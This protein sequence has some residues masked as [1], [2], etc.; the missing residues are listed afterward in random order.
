MSES[1]RGKRAGPDDGAPVDGGRSTRSNDRRTPL[2]KAV[3][4]IEW[5]AD[6]VQ[7]SYGVREIA[8]GIGMAPSTTHR[9]LNML[10]EAGLLD[11]EEAGRYCFSLRFVGLATR[12]SQVRHPLFQEARRCC[13]KLADESGES[14]Y[15][16]MYEAKTHQFMYTECIESRN[17]I[18]YTM[19]T[20]R[21]MPLYPGAG[22]VSILAFLPSDE[23]QEVLTDLPLTRVTDRTI[24]DRRQVRKFLDTTAGHGFVV[25]V[26]QRI[27][28]G[29]GVGAPLFGPDG[30]VQGNIVM[31]LPEDRLARYEANEL[32]RAVKAAADSASAAALARRPALAAP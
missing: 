26:S 25:S 31:A 7:P 2:L 13:R 11:T 27:P 22:G 21:M 14:I 18:T 9:L 24:T 28:G 29:A 1:K 10:E 4:V 12:L 5:M 8:Q 20:F 23:Q 16:G 17:P 19:P 6:T 3:R 32:G 15:I 30:S